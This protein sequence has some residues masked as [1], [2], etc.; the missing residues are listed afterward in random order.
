MITTETDGQA[1]E[2]GSFLLSTDRE[3]GPLL[4]PDRRSPSGSSLIRNPQDPEDPVTRSPRITYV[5]KVKTSPRI[6][7]VSDVKRSPLADML[8]RKY[9][10]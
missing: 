5:S 3:V 4:D 1:M 10:S 6:T 9:F 7:Y 2:E 8:V